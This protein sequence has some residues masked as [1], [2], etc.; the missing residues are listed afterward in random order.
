ML[1]AF[2]DQPADSGCVKRAAQ[3]IT[4]CA[5]RQLSQHQVER[6][7]KV[8]HGV[9]QRAVQIDDRRIKSASVLAKKIISLHAKLLK[10]MQAHHGAHRLE[11]VLGFHRLGNVAVGAA[12]QSFN[13]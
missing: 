3:R 4:A 10:L 9:H 13:N 8:A 1:G 11:Q 5:L 6:H 12:R 2:T 7:H